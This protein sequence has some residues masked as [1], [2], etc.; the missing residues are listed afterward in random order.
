MKSRGVRRANDRRVL[1][2]ILWVP[3]SGA[4]WRDLPENY[5][6]RTTY[7]AASFFGGKRP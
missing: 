5:G 7:A 6:P 1:N 2:Y 4:P 3:R